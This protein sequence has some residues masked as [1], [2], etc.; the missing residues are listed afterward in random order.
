[1]G[2]VGEGAGDGAGAGSGADA[3][4]FREGAA[5]LGGL[6]VAVGRVRG[7]VVTLTTGDAVSATVGAS[8]GVGS[9]AV[10]ADIG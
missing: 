1:L 3:A 7:V 2:K 4:G 10:G 8:A 6:E 9:I 5:D